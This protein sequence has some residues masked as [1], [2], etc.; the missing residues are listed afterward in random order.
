M[1]PKWW[2]RPFW[3]LRPIRS[4]EALCGGKNG[5]PGQFPAPF[6]PRSAFDKSLESSSG[7]RPDVDTHKIPFRLAG[8]SCDGYGAHC[9]FTPRR[10]LSARSPREAAIGVVQSYVRFREASRPH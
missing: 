7:C 10:P 9:I 6:H 5:A 1:R 2:P 4:E 3:R 8:W